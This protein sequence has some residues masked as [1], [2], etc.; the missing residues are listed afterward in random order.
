MIS[1]KTILIVED[2]QTLHKALVDKFT[3]EGF[4]VLQANDG[5]EGLNQ[6][7]TNHPDLILLD[8][9]MPKMD[10]ITMLKK[11]QATEAGSRIPVI[12]LTNLTDSSNMAGAMG[13]G[14]D[15]LVKSDWRIE[16]VVKKVKEKLGMGEA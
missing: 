10:G 9:I 4:L 3:R 11:L 6:A 7:L 5:Q 16:D 13:G 1:P 12:F 15:Y 2:D 14:F 8:I